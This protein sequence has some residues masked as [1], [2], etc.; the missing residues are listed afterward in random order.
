MI[1][2]NRL[3]RNLVG[4]ITN[5]I[6]FNC[7]GASFISFLFLYNGNISQSNAQSHL[8]L[9]QNLKKQNS[10]LVINTKKYEE[11]YNSGKKMSYL[12]WGGLVLSGI[13]SATAFTIGKKYGK[14]VLM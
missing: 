13:A 10:N 9:I 14:R 7:I 11:H 4:R 12:G 6:M 5:T 8:D 2:Q 3:R 1:K